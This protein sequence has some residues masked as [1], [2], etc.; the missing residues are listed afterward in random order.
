MHGHDQ[1]PEV[2]CKQGEFSDD[3]RAFDKDEML[4]VF[5]D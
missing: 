4:S 2:A 3:L 1:P 5:M